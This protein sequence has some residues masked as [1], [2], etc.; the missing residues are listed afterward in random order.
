MLASVLNSDTAIEVSIQIIRVFTRMREYLLE[1][2]DI[3]LKL[4][5]IQKKLLKQD[6]RMQKHEDEI[7]MIFSAL[8]ELLNPPLPP[9]KQIGFKRIDEEK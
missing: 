3:L 5:K 1:H 2:G 6:H 8:K 4:E 7:Q 9:R